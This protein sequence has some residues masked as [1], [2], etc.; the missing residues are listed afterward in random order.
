MSQVSGGFALTAL[1]DGTTINGYVRVDNMPLVQRY[2][3][4]SNKFTPDFEQTPENNRPV[5]IAVN[6]DIT[7]GTALS[8]QTAVFKYNSVELAF[9]PDGLCTTEGFEGVFKKITDYPAQIGSVSLPMVAM[10]IMKNLVPLS[11]YDNDR[12]S[13]SGTVEVN[14]QALQF[15]EMST[16]V[17]IQETTGNQ[18]D[19][20]ITNDKGSA[21][22]EPGEQL[23]EKVDLYRDGVKVSELS[24]FTFQWVKVT[25]E[26]DQNLGT[27]Q[28][29][30][31]TT[32]DVNNVLKV[33]CDVSQD[34][35]IVASGYD[36]ISDFSDPYYVQ[37]NITGI[38]GTH[39]RKGQTAKVTPV[40]VKRS[41]GEVNES[42]VTNWTFRIRDN[43]GKDFK[44]TGKDGPSFTDKECNISFSD[45]KDAGM[46][47]N[48][49]VTANF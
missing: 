11:G 44:L 29:Q 1:M 13:I 10:R 2:T 35:T 21:F 7:D 3:K 25:A 22:S 26:G 24:S 28:T 20:V 37:F 15:N 16:P 5:V 32:D 48:G 38:D 42:L 19:V 47:I 41:T 43:A 17:T 18:F 23:T 40:A 9:G 49:Y 12:I 31:I 27:A 45:V 14:G 36:E 46:G 39:I 8:P 33:R 4:G 34:G 30:V 6:R